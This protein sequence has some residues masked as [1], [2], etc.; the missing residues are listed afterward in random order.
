M[1]STRILS[2]VSAVALLL[3]SQLSFAAAVPAQAEKAG[4]GYNT[5]LIVLLSLVI[6]LVF[7][8]GMLSNTLIQLTAVVKDKLRKDRKSGSG[9][10]K[11]ILILLSFSL[12]TIDLLAQ[13]PAVEK[14]A[15]VSTSIGS[16][17]ESDFYTI[18]TVLALELIIIFAQVMFIKSL[19]KT[20]KG[21]P[22]LEGAAVVSKYNWFWDKFNAAAPIEKEKDV[23]LD[24]DYDGIQE[25]DNSL[26]PWWKYGFYLTIIVGA[27]YLYRFHISHDGLRASTTRNSWRPASSKCRRWTT[28]KTSARS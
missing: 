22:E 9:V 3:M 18:I 14:V 8:I 2:F 21:N 17:A 24:H 13:K 19:L 7:M 11:V 23:L 25:L 10:A 16:I 4:D 12:P 1:R 20:I 6:V 28:R 26:P 15:P 27:I 5:V